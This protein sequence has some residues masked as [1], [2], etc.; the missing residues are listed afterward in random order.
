MS[1]LMPMVCTKPGCPHVMPCPVHRA[2]RKPRPSSAGRGYGYAHQQMRRRVLLEEP[3]CRQCGRPT[4]DA[5]HII[6]VSQGGH[7]GRSN[8]QG[9]CR[10]CNNIKKAQQ[11]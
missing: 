10:R 2:P 8:Y 7:A 4:Q 6:P 5:D 9:L 1:R 3:Y 11:R